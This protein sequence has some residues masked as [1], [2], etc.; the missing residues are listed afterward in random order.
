MASVDNKTSTSMSIPSVAGSPKLM[1]DFISSL[2]RC[3]IKK[4]QEQ[5]ADDKMY[6]APFP[7]RRLG[8]LAYRMF[9]SLIKLLRCFMCH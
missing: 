5:G 3:S 9:I 7:T 1:E 6:L 2:L 8:Q 4:K